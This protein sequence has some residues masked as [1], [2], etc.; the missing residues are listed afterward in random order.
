MYVNAGDATKRH[1]PYSPYGNSGR[2][3]WGVNI[4]KFGNACLGCNGTDGYFTAVDLGNSDFDVFGS[5]GN[6]C[7]V[8]GWVRCD[9][10]VGSNEKLINQYED[11]NNNWQLFRNTDGTL[12]LYYV[13]GGSVYIDISGGSVTQSTWHHVALC[14]VGAETGI[15]IDGTQVAYDATFN[16]DTFAGNLFIGAYGPGGDYFDG[17]LQ[18]WTICYQ[19]IFGA[20]P[21]VG[22]TDTIDV[23]TN[24]P[25]GL[26]I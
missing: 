23:D 26:V 5:T 1:V 10:A 22:V 7:T 20:A 15:Y 12:R 16:A 25:L 11:A 19:N 2:I 6:D 13:S 24:N 4:A 8:C 17:R 21:V 3:N 9:D 18:D 14:K